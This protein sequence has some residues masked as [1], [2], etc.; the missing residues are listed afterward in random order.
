MIKRTSAIL[1]SKRLLRLYSLPF[2]LCIVTF[3]SC[4]T[5]S[6]RFLEMKATGR[7]L[8]PA[9]SIHSFSGMFSMATCWIFSK[10]FSGATEGLDDT[11]DGQL[12]LEACSLPKTPFSSLVLKTRS[13]RWSYMLLVLLYLWAPLR[14]DKGQCSL[15]HSN[16]SKRKG[17]EVRIF[18]YSERPSGNYP[19]LKAWAVFLA[20][21][22]LPSTSKTEPLFSINCFPSVKKRKVVY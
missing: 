12:S 20:K 1:D 10:G 11:E 6:H 19:P 13:S 17:C 2:V 16:P 9:T 7:Q 4:H 8:T 3:C 18:F 14:D 21:G 15:W 22:H 5:A